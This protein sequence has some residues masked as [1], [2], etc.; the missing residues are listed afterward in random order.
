MNK[1]VFGQRNMLFSHFFA[2]AFSVFGLSY[3]INQ[4][5]RLGYIK[6]LNEMSI[7]A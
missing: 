6:C 2:K 5:L 1:L 7:A 3:D 4:H